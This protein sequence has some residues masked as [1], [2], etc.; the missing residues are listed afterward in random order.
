M[1]FTVTLA[2]VNATQTVTVDYATA[3]QSATAAS[4]DYVAAGG[5]LTFNPSVA[6]QT[7]S[8]TVNGDT[9]V[10]ANE[11]FAVNLSNAANAL[12]GDAQGIGTITN[13]DRSRRSDGDRRGHRGRGWHDLRDGLRRTRQSHGL[14]RRGSGGSPDNAYARWVYLNGMSTPPSAGMSNAT[15]LLP[16]PFTPGSYVRPVLRE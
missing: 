5:T 6:T 11:S 2:P 3:D 8:V 16:A 9:G 1:T 14:G 13:N 4:G 7:I 12:V 10:E 15:F